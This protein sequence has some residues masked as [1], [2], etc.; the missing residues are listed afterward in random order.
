MSWKDL[1]QKSDETIVAPWVGGR[2]LQLGARTYTIDPPFPREHGW[3]TFRVG[4]GG[5]KLKFDVAAEPLPTMFIEHVR[6]YLVGDWIVPDD[7]RVDPDPAK[8]IDYA[9]PVLLVEAGLDRFVRVQAGRLNEGGPL[10]FEGQEMPLGPEEDVLQA[11]FNRIPDL[12]KVKG[13]MPALDAAF[14]M[15]VWQRA[16]AQRRREEI[17]RLRKEEEAKRELEERRQEIVKRLG[18]G[19]GRR[20]LA[21]IDFAEA[22]R[23]ALK[24]AGAEYLDHRPSKGRPNEMTVTFRHIRRQ[25]ECT[26]NAQTLQIVDSGICLRDHATGEKGDGYFTLESLPGVIAQADRERR[27]VVFRH[28]GDDRNWYDGRE[29][30]DDPEEDEDY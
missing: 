1:L 2:Q 4:G 29:E 22:A 15:E 20:A 6:G 8:I 3:Y 14:R 10:I 27:L 23:A 16:E 24:V 19:A 30:R 18:D 26:C 9:K 13:V 12:D 28:I 11:Y 17:E 7:T 25:F 5:R 21:V